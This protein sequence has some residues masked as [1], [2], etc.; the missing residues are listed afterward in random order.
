[1]TNEQYFNIIKYYC[2]PNT[3][4]PKEKYQTIPDEHKQLYV[5][6]AAE[7]IQ[8]V[9]FKYNHDFQNWSNHEDMWNSILKK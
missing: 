3:K 8:N 1:M 4:Y 2:Y 6:A 9:R 5:E 7:F